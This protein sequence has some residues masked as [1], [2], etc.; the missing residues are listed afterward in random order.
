MNI[1]ANPYLETSKEMYFILKQYHKKVTKDKTEMDILQEPM[2]VLI[3]LPLEVLVEG[4]VLRV[5]L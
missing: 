4:R 2:H 3:V 1:Y 5:M